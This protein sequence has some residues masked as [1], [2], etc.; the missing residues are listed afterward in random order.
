[1]FNPAPDGAM[2]D[3]EEI[4]V[5]LLNSLVHQML[6]LLH[7]PD[8]PE[9]TDPL[10]LLIGMNGPT[11]ISDDPVLARLFPDAYPESAED[12]A[13]FRRF[14]WPDLQ[15]QKIHHAHAVLEMLKSFPGESLI[16]SQSLHS[17]LLTLNDLRLALGTRM[18]LENGGEV[19]SS[20]ED[21]APLFGVYDWLSGLQGTLIE[22]LEQ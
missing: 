22:V 9:S 16:S 14:T 6:Q 21:I 13:E 10:A 15:Q 3:L 20:G 7:D 2:L 1:M 19:N 5:E 8:E 11:E 4:E 18:G 17:W 12:S